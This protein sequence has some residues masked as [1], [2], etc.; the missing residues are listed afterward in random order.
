MKPPSE[1][2]E[3]LTTQGYIGVTPEPPLMHGIENLFRLAPL[4]FE[5]RP[6][7][8]RQYYSPVTGEGYRPLGIEYSLSTDR[9]DLLESFSCS[10]AH[11]D[12]AVQIPEGLGC[13]LY[14]L[15]IEIAE[16]ES[17]VAEA[18]AAALY[19]QLTGRPAP[20]G[21]LGCR[22]WSRLQLNYYKPATA[23]RDLL[24]DPHEDGDLFT[25]ASA[26]SP[27]LEL[28]DHSGVFRAPQHSVNDLLLFPG[29]ILWL[30][31]G[32]AILPTFHRV[33]RTDAHTRC[34]LVYFVDPDPTDLRPWIETT[35]N[36]NVAIGER[37]ITNWS[38]SGVPP[39]RQMD[40]E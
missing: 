15:M 14:K 33:R 4:F 1:L 16:L 39:V 30:L 17:Q 32:G 23:P 26:T 31:S 3:G 40:S 22:D 37:V 35:L 28:C 12:A 13:E 11:A 20:S 7:A 27:G 29:E 10:A 6:A 21:V 38:R 2:K 5:Q 18:V 19:S 34:S 8:K 9:P 24:Q 36:Y 25:I